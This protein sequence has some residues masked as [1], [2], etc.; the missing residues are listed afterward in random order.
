MSLLMQVS[1]QTLFFFKNKK[2]WRSFLPSQIAVSAALS[3]V[4]AFFPFFTPAETAEF[5]LRLNP[6]S[7]GVF[8]L[9]FPI[10][11]LATM[12]QVMRVIFYADGA[13]KTFLPVPNG[14]VMR[15]ALV[16][17]ENV[18]SALVWGV[19]AGYAGLY[20]MQLFLKLPPFGIDTVAVIAVMLA[21]Y[22]VIRQSMSLPAKIANGNAGLAYSWRLTRQCGMALCLYY[23]INAFFPLLLFLAVAVYV[24]FPEAVNNFLALMSLFFS[25]MIQAAFLAYLY[26]RLK[27]GS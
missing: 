27:D 12:V 11:V 14:N 21:P 5:V 13:E 3:C 9:V 2:V 1:G 25:A 7:V 18:V 17:A 8:L 22:C 10:T 23:L 20:A 6:W 4:V 16:L 19:L 26:I 15:F 24:P